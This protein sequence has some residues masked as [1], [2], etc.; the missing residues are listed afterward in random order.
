MSDGQWTQEEHEAHLHKAAQAT[1]AHLWSRK[2]VKQQSE[3]IVN[4][5]VKWKIG[6]PASKQQGSKRIHQYLKVHLPKVFPHREF[7]QMPMNLFVRMIQR[8]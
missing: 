4:T 8:R 6:E 1:N 2:A 7:F 3:P 5:L